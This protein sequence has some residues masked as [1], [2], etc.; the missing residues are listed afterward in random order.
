M[1]TIEQDT[2]SKQFFIRFR[3]VGRSYKR[4]LKTENKKDAQ[5]ALSRLNETLSLVQRGFLIMPP[6]ADPAT[7]FLSGGKATK[8]P[9]NERGITLGELFTKYQ[10]AL[11]VQA[12]K[13]RPSKP[14]R[15]T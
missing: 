6:D 10:S 3:F 1:A 14:K 5:S 2:S 8:R 9:M 15:H 4:S 13:K 7:Y 12:K 11:P